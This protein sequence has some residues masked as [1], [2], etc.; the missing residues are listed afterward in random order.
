MKA[1]NHF[2]NTI[3]AY[4]DKRA[5]IDLLFSFRYSLPEKKL[6]DCILCK[7]IHKQHYA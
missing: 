1:T 2:Q 6:E 5:E 7:A 4:L 3:K